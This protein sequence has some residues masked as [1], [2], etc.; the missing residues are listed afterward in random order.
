MLK[1]VKASV[2]LHRGSAF[3]GQV[4]VA[5]DIHLPHLEAELLNRG[6]RGEFA[7]QL[8]PDQ[9][10]L[11]LFGF[12]QVLGR[13]SLGAGRRVF[14]EGNYDAILPIIKLC[15]TLD[16]KQIDIYATGMWH[17]GYNFTDEQQR[18]DRRYISLRLR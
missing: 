17:I 10:L 8:S 9:I 15:T 11:Q 18:S 1:N 4:D 12:P 5:E 3:S 14:D 7:S 2:G 16:P 6:R 13:H